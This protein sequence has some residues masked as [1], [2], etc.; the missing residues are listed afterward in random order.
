MKRDLQWP[1]LPLHATLPT[2]CRATVG[3]GL[4]TSHA[5]EMSSP[6]MPLLEMDGSHFLASHV[7][8]AAAHVE[9]CN[10]LKDKVCMELFVA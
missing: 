4:W 10:E 7:E 1:S 8:T 6:A 3:W 5:V 2:L 9:L